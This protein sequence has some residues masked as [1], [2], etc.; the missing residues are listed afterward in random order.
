ML[1]QDDY[2]YIG[3]EGGE[4]PAIIVYTPEDSYRIFVVRSD[5]ENMIKRLQQFLKEL[6][7]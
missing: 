3:L 2:G 7:K 5:V 6:P 1:I 4:K